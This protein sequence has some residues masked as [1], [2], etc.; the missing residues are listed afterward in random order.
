MYNL[1]NMEKPFVKHFAAQHPDVTFAGTPDKLTS[2]NVGLAKGA[3]GISIHFNSPEKSLYS[4]LHKFGVKIIGV[5]QTG[6]NE[7]DL[8]AAKKNHLVVTNVPGYSPRS[9]AEMALT[10]VMYLLRHI[11][12]IR[13]REAKGDFLWAGDEAREIHNLT[14][15]VIGT[16]KIGGTSAKI[17]K[18]LG[19]KVLGS[20]PYPNPQLKSTLTYVPLKTLLQT[21]DVIVLHTPLLKSTRHMIGAKEFKLMKNSV[22]FVNVSRGAVV[23]TNALIDALKDH[24]I[25][26]AG[27]DTIEDEGNT[28]NRDN[29]GT[30]PNQYIKQLINMPNV[31]ITPHVAYDTD[32]S[33]KNMVEISLN[34]IYDVINGKSVKDQL[35]K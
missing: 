33:V 23:D 27:L 1:L 25:A 18:A 34:D 29:K 20:D 31:L 2:K 16:G 28:F 5:R 32:N 8:D 13:Q 21:A 10:H 15:G 17:Y 24:E 6:Y 7:V 19:A 11:G 35:N 14:V 3:D 30:I 26:A 12:D 4:S 9:V 22:I